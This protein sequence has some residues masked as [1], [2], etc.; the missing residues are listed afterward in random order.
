MRI[1]FIVA[2]L[3]AMAL[4]AAAADPVPLAGEQS[5]WRGFDRFLFQT[6]AW[7]VRAVAPRDPAPGLPWVLTA[8]DDFG[9]VDAALLAKGFHVVLA[10]TP[11]PFGSPQ[12]VAC[13]DAVYAVM[14]EKHGF[15][16]KVVLEGP[17]PGGLLA[18]NWAAR[19]PDKVA[20]IYADGPVLDF[21]SWPG[22]ANKVARDQDRWQALLAAYGFASDEEAFAYEG[23]PLDTLKPIADAEIPLLHLAGYR[24]PIAPYDEHTGALQERYWRAGGARLELFMK[25]DDAAVRDLPDPTAIVYFVLKH[26]GDRVYEPPAA[27]PE[28]LAPWGVSAFD[29]TGK[30]HVMDDVI[31]LEKGDDMTGITWD[32]PPHRMNYEIAL[33]AMR[34]EGSD[35][36]CGLTFPVNDAPCSL[37]VGGWGGTCVGLSSLDYNDA[38]NNETARFRDFYKGR[39]YAIRLRVTE[40]RIQA[41]IDDEPIVD[42][43]IEGRIVDIRWEVEPSKP[44]GIATWRTSA[45]LRNIRMRPVLP[46]AR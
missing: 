4:T 34:V 31:F 10:E 5:A 46:E 45:A 24:N 13:W 20:C 16:R 29:R 39:W 6:D 18:Y 32:A 42:A 27:T 44:L 2:V 41:W 23:N 19:N 38:Y 1:S 21:K 9:A 37:I 7:T 11:D 25:P 35:F 3:S 30:V 28:Q 12:A 14:T 36:F 22:G 40:G 26:T 17:G 43:N 15:Q 33:D 8:A